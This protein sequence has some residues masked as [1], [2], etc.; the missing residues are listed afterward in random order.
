MPDRF[1]M[2]ISEE[3]L[4]MVAELTGVSD[5]PFEDDSYLIIEPISPT[6][7]NLKIVSEDTA[8]EEFKNDSKLHI[9]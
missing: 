1:A 8:V 4:A 9:L 7:Y 2:K 6:E 5:S 3:L